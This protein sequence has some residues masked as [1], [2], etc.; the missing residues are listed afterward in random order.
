MKHRMD[1][2]SE[3]NQL[4]GNLGENKN[5]VPENLCKQNF[6]VNKSVFFWKNAL[7]NEGNKMFV[8]YT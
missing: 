1:C 5:N 4:N 8:N 6:L 3:R 2:I 7:S